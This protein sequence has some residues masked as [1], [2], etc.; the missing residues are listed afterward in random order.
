[1]DLK[2]VAETEDKFCPIKAKRK[3]YALTEL[4]KGITPE[5]IQALKAATVWALNGAPVGGELI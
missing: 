4:M 5:S 1:V 3:R 2:P